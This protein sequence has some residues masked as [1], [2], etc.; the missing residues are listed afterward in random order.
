MTVTVG[1]WLGVIKESRWA[2]DVEQTEME[3]KSATMPESTILCTVRIPTQYISVFASDPWQHCQPPDD[4]VGWNSIQI[5]KW[6]CN[7]KQQN[8]QFFC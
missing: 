6:L 7:K 3:F 4:R 1:A 2:L 5:S 8:A